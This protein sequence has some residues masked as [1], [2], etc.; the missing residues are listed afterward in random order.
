[1]DATVNENKDPP[2]L[3]TK[4][5]DK[6]DNESSPFPQF[7]KSPPTIKDLDKFIKES[8]VDRNESLLEAT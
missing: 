4:M 2:V 8:F 5:K 3:K 7:L 6:G 1:M